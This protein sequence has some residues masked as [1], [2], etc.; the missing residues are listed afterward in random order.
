MNTISF[1]EH[2]EHINNLEVGEKVKL[3]ILERTYDFKPI[4]EELIKAGYLDKFQFKS[5]NEYFKNIGDIDQKYLDI[6]LKYYKDLK[7]KD[8]ILG[9]LRHINFKY[10]ASI[11]IDIFNHGDN[12]VKWRVCEVIEFKR[13]WWGIEE[14]IF[15]TLKDKHY[16]DEVSLLV[17]TIPKMLPRINA[18]EF[19]KE[20]FELRP[21][22]SSEAIEKIGGES[23]LYFL[24]ERLKEFENGKINPDINSKL[25][26]KSIRTA[27]KKIQKKLNSKR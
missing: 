26:I 1:N 23:E 10:D 6:V 19:L 9:I 12:G 25:I 22:I 13:A 21:A 8:Q 15:S 16:K 2:I 7:N 18:L 3:N 14:W 5:D 4:N 24:D 17:L 11:L 27:I 20:I